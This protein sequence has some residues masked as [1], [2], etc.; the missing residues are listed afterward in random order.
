M[1]VPDSRGRDG[2]RVGRTVHASA[3]ESEATW[4]RTKTCLIE[5]KAYPTTLFSPGEA[6]QGACT[7]KSTIYTANI[8]AGLM[9]GQFTKRL[10]GLPIDAD[11]QFNI[12]TSEI[13]CLP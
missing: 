9:A 4:R 11:L 12:L 10:R 2:L 1:Q 13:T 7:A 8:A 5:K 3:S 6:H